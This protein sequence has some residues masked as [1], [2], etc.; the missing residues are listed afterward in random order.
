PVE[1]FRLAGP[2]VTTCKAWAIADGRTGDL[3]FGYNDAAVRDPASITKI[4]TAYVVCRAVESDPSVLEE[5]VTFSRRADETTG[6]SA[7][8]RAGERVSVGELLYGLMLPSGNDASVAFAEHFGAKLPESMGEAPYDRFIQAMNDT[9]AELGM[10]ETGYKNPHGLTAKGHVTTAGDMIKLAH[11]AMQMPHFRAVV[12]TRQRGATLR[13][14]DGYARDVVW[15]N[16]NRLLGF[17]GFYGVKTGTTGPAGECLVSAGERGGR[18]LLMVVL[19]ANR[20]GGRY[21]DSRNLYRWVWR[22]LG[23]E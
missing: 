14:V 22:E 15:N 6:S 21:V 19:G 9:A 1:A 4:M 12:K 16:S 8:V 10:S 17:E 18:P 11:A 13:S 2:P 7:T 20:G 3:L 5:I 23:V